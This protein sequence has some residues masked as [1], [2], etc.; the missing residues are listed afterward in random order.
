MMS[1]A[2]ALA[3]FGVLAAGCASAEAGDPVPTTHVSMAKSYRFDPARIVVD[4]GSV[5]T[6]TNDDN[7]THTVHVD[8]REDR[9]VGRGDEVGIRFDQPGTYHYVCCLHPHDMSGDVIVR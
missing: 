5:V 8:G 9:K 3:T 2:L 4:P 7:F 1:A 6:W